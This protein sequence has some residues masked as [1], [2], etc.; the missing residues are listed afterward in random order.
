MESVT[1][2]MESVQL[3]P[4]VSSEDTLVVSE[5]EC[6]TEAGPGGTRIQRK[7]VSFKTAAKQ[8]EFDALCSSLGIV[9]H[10]RAVCEHCDA[11]VLARRIL[12]AHN[13]NRALASSTFLSK[14]GGCDL[15][16]KKDP[17]GKLKKHVDS[18]LHKLVL[19]LDTA[20]SAPA[21]LSR[22]LVGNNERLVRLLRTLLH[23]TWHYRSFLQFEHEIYLQQLQGLD[24]GNRNHSRKTGRAMLL[25]IGELW[26]NDMKE[27][28]ATPNAFTGRLP[29]CGLTGDKVSLY[30]KQYQIAMIF[31]AFRGRRKVLLLDLGRVGVEKIEPKSWIGIKVKREFLVDVEG[32]D[33]KVAEVFDGIV[34][35]YLP[36]SGDQVEDLWTIVY[37]DDDQEEYDLRDLNFYATSFPLAAEP[38]AGAAACMAKFGTA[39]E[40]VGVAF[41]DKTPHGQVAQLRTFAGDGEGTYQGEIS[42]V[43]ARLHAIDASIEVTH[44][45]PHDQDLGIS[46]MRK[47]VTYL[48]TIH[49]VCSGVYAHYSVSPKKTEGLVREA[50]LL[51]TDL[52]QL[53]YIFEV[54]FCASERIAFRAL[55]H[56]LPV[57]VIALS[58]ELQVHEGNGGPSGT[59]R[60][61]MNDWIRKTK[62]LKFIAHMLIQLD[63]HH[64][65]DIFSKQTQSNELLI[66]EYPD[67][68]RSYKQHLEELEAGGRGRG[69]YVSRALTDLQKGYFK[70]KDGV[71][72]KLKLTGFVEAGGEDKAAWVRAKIDA[73]QKE[74]TGVL[75][76]ELEDRL[77]VAEVATQLRTV[78]HVRKLPFLRI[79]SPAA[80]DELKQ[81]GGDAIDWLVANKFKHMVPGVVKLHFRRFYEFVRNEWASFERIKKKDG[82]RELDLLLLFAYVSDTPDVAREMTTVVEI[83]EYV[84]SFAFGSCENERLG[85]VMTLTK[86]EMRTQLGDDAF[87]ALCF[88]KQSM[89]SLEAVDFLRIVEAW[90]KSGHCSARSKRRSLFRKSD[91]TERLK[92]EAAKRDNTP[93][94][95]KKS[96]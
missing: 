50:A 42:G 65:N 31:Y 47:T 49:L 52:R 44:D 57:I 46:A 78:L 43:K 30:V 6:D 27:F 8:E 33:E 2:S 63:L 1:S 5:D 15:T 9:V 48:E 73:W 75:L 54:R 76:T 7:P 61:K 92:H 58:K 41:N 45:P 81:H 51:E 34:E 90:Y 80:D 26:M 29:Y 23:N 35:A 93:I 3:D 94:G 95:T 32:Q 89:P 10:W 40:K 86:T 16:S 12:P 72:I 22:A 28:M 14:N 37:N 24:L 69:G 20:V 64:E 62:E 74:L 87:F 17:L 91:V 83:I 88:I 11:A 19:Q 53:H 38:P 67:V 84:L 70:N 68:Q 85:R 60:V 96:V 79:N 82:P 59:A 71:E 39:L 66:L 21:S 25:V 18:D 4:W 77:R 36:A 56:D 55:M 13:L